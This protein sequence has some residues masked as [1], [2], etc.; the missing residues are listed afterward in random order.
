MTSSKTV[1]RYDVVIIG[2]GSAGAVIAS[3]V[4]EDPNRSVLLL[5]AGPDY[6][7]LAETP[8]DLVNAY[9]NSVV[10][11]DWGHEYRPTAEFPG[12]AVPSRAG[13]GWIERGE[14]GDRAARDSRGLR[15]VG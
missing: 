14:H 12:D 11:H 2:A 13:D 15:P 4:S 3:R 1:P 10:D 7:Q 6:P 8:F 5:D 9:R